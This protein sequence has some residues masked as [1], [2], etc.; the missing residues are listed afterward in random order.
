METSA[1]APRAWRMERRFLIIAL[2]LHGMT[3]GIDAELGAR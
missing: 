3:P 2:G 1:N